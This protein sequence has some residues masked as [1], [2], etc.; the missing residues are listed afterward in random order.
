MSAVDREVL[1]RRLLGAV[2]LFGGLFLLSL[3]LP[4]GSPPELVQLDADR[5]QRVR[6]D[7]NPVPVPMPAAVPEESLE[8]E[9]DGSPVLESDAGAPGESLESEGQPVE[10]PTHTSAPQPTPKPAPKSVE[11][12]EP[13]KQPAPQKAPEP[14]SPAD[15]GWWVQ[16]AS[17][18]D[19][20]N[21]ARLV[22]KLKRS[23]LPARRES[24]TISQRTLYRVLVGPYDDKA[25]ADA[26]RGRVILLG[27]S[28]S[29]SLKR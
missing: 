5:T 8:S 17:F 1:I 29:R 10:P 24:V 3:L 7:L 20:G 12:E 25:A 9:A 23:G 16:V 15:K 14:S 13:P 28:D 19:A 27:F 22:D 2:V 4:G 26:A 6:I 21:A 11:R 18:G